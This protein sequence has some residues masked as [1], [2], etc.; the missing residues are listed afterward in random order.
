MDT[1]HLVMACNSAGGDQNEWM[2]ELLKFASHVHI[3]DAI[4]EDGEGVNFGDGELKFKYLS[5]IS[6]KLRLI[7]EQWEGHLDNFKGFKK[8]LLFIESIK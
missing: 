1:A 4:G 8:A 6:K 3:A 2:K 5:K 7:I